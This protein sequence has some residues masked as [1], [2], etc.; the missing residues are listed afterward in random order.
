MA[1]VV[2]QVLAGSPPANQPPDGNPGGPR[3]EVRPGPVAFKIVGDADGR[4]S[5]GVSA[6]IDFALTNAHDNALTIS[7]FRVVVRE[8]SAPEADRAHPCGV[9]DFTVD[10]VA[11]RREIT[12]PAASTRTLTALGVPST[13]LPR[14]GMRDLSVNQD[15]CKGASLSLDYTASAAAS[16]S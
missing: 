5:P 16:T 14:V 6:P 3:A 2:M 4:I 13:R 11:S 10:Q 9:G 7:N 1:A 8:V 12:L 15:G